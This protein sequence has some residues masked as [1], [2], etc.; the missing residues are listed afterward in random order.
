MGWDKGRVGMG[1]RVGKF[2][3]WLGWRVKVSVSLVAS[4][5]SLCWTHNISVRDAEKTKISH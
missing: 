5:Y 1:G 2:K 4:G 3:G